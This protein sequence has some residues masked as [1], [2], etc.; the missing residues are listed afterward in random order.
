MFQ[1]KI[2]KLPDFFEVELLNRLV[3]AMG[4]S[5]IEPIMEMNISVLTIDEILSTSGQEVDL[6]EVQFKDDGTFLYH[7]RRVILHIRDIKAYNDQLMLP[8]FHLSNCKTLQAMGAKKR[9][10]RYV[11]STRHDGQFRINISKDE[12]H[13]WLNQESYLDVCK[14][15][16]SELNWNNYSHSKEK[17]RIFS[18]FK[19]ESFFEK[20]P[21]APVTL[22][23]L[24]TDI[25]APLNDYT[26]DFNE[27]SL[28][29]RESKNWCCE[30]CS[31]DLSH[32]ELKRYL[33][34]HH[35]NSIKS[36][37]SLHNLQ[38]LCI[39][40]HAAQDSH[41]HLGFSPD[42]HEYH[43]ITQSLSK[44]LS[45]INLSTSSANVGDVRDF[46]SVEDFV[47]KFSIR[48]ENY[49]D[50]GGNFWVY[51]KQGQHPEVDSKLD[52]LGFKYKAERGWWSK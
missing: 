6:S 41:S 11:V 36:D 4:A 47:R 48:T 29:Y 50:N 2:S 39:S 25:S 10:E 28:K 14:N 38:A 23:P 33:H 44:K 42:F 49:C 43:R 12:G 5:K 34:V 46:S 51:V 8:R 31:A 17:S 45:D 15:C 52:S 37:N 19:L 21:N 13:T 35:V 16:L 26:R 3:R 20:Y 1:F 24:H 22:T 30:L 40:C 9:S 7:G 27:I 18:E 32:K